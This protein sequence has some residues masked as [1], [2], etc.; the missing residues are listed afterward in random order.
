MI[1]TLKR[2]VL[3]PPC[4]VEGSF[5]QFLVVFFCCSS[6][7]PSRSRYFK[8]TDVHLTSWWFTHL[9]QLK[10]TEPLLTRWPKFL[11]FFFSLLTNVLPAHQFLFTILW[12]A[13]FSA[14]TLSQQE[15]HRISLRWMNN[16]ILTST[17]W[18]FFVEFHLN[19][20]LHPPKKAINDK[21]TDP[22]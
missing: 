10:P 21:R 16:G 8:K 22:L 11:I 2:A 4:F 1:P 6:I 15:E 17:M 18:T 14:R 12:H 3:M 7:V 19:L 20:L 13:C 9:C 5:L